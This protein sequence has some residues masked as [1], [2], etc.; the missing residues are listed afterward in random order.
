MKYASI[1][2]EVARLEIAARREVAERLNERTNAE[3][4]QIS[5]LLQSDT[6]RTIFEQAMGE[7]FN[8]IYAQRAK[9][10]S[11]LMVYSKMWE[12]TRDEI[13]RARR[14]KKELDMMITR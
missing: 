14:E 12:W 8:R 2:H 4:E 11:K 3:Y 1:E 7:R 9:L 5:K 13:D 10:W 6:A